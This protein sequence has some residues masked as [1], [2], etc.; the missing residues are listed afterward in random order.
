MSLNI[1]Q[2]DVGTQPNDGTGVPLRE[3]FQLINSNFASIETVVG[4]GDFGNI[5]ANVLATSGITTDTLE[6]TDTATVN[7]L[8]ANTAFVSG[9]LV[10]A[11]IVGEL[12]GNAASATKLLPG[13]LLNGIPF[14]GTQDVNFDIGNYTIDGGGY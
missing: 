1:T 4:S 11:N 2:I 6:V 10:A 8:G 5:S 3:A 7:S 13:C 12:D 14:D 9:T